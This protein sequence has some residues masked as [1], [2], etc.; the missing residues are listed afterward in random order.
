VSTL[1]TARPGS[2]A[3]PALQSVSIALSV[4]DALAAAPEL[5]LSELARRVGVAKSTAHRTCAVLTTAG[6]LTRTDAG[7]YRLG[8]RLIEYG[9]LATA[10]SPVGEHGLPLLVELR[11]A[12]R[13]DGPDRGARGR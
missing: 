6:M 2:D 7:R 1:T 9:H 13:R 8:L 10:R 3:K 12:A 4:L 5:S 11:S